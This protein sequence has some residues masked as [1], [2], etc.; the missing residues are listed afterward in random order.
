MTAEERSS[1]RQADTPQSEGEHDEIAKHETDVVTVIP[2]AERDFRGVF[3]DVERAVS[4][5]KDMRGHTHNDPRKALPL[6][7]LMAWLDP[8][9]LPAWTTG[10]YVYSLDRTPAA[11]QRA[12]A[13]L[14]EGLAANPNSLELHQAL[15]Q[16]YLLWDHEPDLARKHLEAATRLG[17]T[18]GWPLPEDTAEALLAAYR[19]LALLQRDVGDRSAM[20]RTAWEGLRRFPDDRVL[21]RLAVDAPTIYTEEH[22]ERLLRRAME[23]A[24]LRQP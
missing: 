18:M 5:Y 23:L 9:F 12:I 16:A 19:W 24:Q 4:A 17:D 20:R 10:A 2:P 1:G 3:G 8:E 13:F 14:R 15:G 22:V 6:L 11:H 7:R 21:A